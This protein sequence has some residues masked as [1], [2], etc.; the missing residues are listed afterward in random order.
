MAIPQ[1]EALGTAHTLPI[2]LMPLLGVSSRELLPTPLA[3]V[4][5]RV[6]RVC[7][8]V[9]TVTIVQAGKR[10]AAFIALVTKG[11]RRCGLNRRPRGVRKRRRVWVLEHSR[12]DER[13][14]RDVLDL[15]GLAVVTLLA[16]LLLLLRRIGMGRRRWL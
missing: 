4:H 11:W 7:A 1:A 2:V 5:R 15:I 16:V 9:M 10:S 3:L 14:R 13:G 6:L 12:C 8:V